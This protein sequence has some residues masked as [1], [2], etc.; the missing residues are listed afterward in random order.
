MCGRIIGEGTTSPDAFIRFLS[1]QNTIEGNYLDGVSV[2]HGASGSR[3][4]IWS[5][6]AGH[7]ARG[8]LVARRSS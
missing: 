4:H 3:T 1:D 5:F 2:T 6:G 7:P 8:G